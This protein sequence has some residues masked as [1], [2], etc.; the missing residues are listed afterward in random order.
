MAAATK[1]VAKEANAAS[2]PCPKKKERKRQVRADNNKILG[3]TANQNFILAS[4][5]IFFNL[6]KN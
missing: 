2:L 6:L 4:I 1:A 3:G 5:L